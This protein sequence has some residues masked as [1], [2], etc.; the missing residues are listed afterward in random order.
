ML[1][2]YRDKEKSSGHLVQCMNNMSHEQNLSS[3]SG[4]PEFVAQYFFEIP[5]SGVL[6]HMEDVQYE[7][8][9]TE[10]KNGNVVFK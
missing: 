8:N 3:N 5:A 6:Y 4:D 10:D 2:H 1:T 9:T 7:S